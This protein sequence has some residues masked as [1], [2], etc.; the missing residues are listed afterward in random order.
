M[1]MPTTSKRSSPTRRANRFTA[2]DFHQRDR[3]ITS[4]ASDTAFQRGE[5]REGRLRPAGQ[6]LGVIDSVDAI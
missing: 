5:I 1:A 3:G 2:F 6:D 4:D